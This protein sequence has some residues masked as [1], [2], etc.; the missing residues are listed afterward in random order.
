MNPPGPPK[1]ESD[2]SAQFGSCG[3]EADDERGF[4][5]RRWSARKHAAG[6]QARDAAKLS[7]PAPPASPMSAGDTADGAIG[8][9]PLSDA[10]PFAT[11]NKST[12]VERT[13]LPPIDSLTQGSDFTPF[14]QPGVP[15]ELRSAALRK[16]FAD[17]RFNVMDGLDVYIDDYSKPDPIAPDIVKTLRHARFI[18]APPQTRVNDRGVVEDVPPAEILP[19]EAPSQTQTQT[20]APAP[21]LADATND[22]ATENAR[23]PEQI[24]NPPDAPRGEKP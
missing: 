4:S 13:L 18:F 11:A 19:A 2:G 22:A 3:R 5:L 6:A 16:L 17:P 9:A 7:K 8:T 15:P 12:A 14:M 20:Q 23:A 1:D 10:A 24:A 21:A